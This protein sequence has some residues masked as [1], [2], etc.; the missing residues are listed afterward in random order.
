[1]DNAQGYIMGYSANEALEPF[2]LLTYATSGVE[3]AD[4]ITERV[5]GV[6][7]QAV[8]SGERASAQVNGVTYLVCDGSGT[9]ITPGARLMPKASADGIGVVAAGATAVPCAIALEGTTAA[10]GVIRVQLTP[11]VAVV[12]S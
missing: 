12:G 1:M 2:R 5:I 4:A 8:A 10:A 11:N 6:S 3:Y 9:A 7:Q